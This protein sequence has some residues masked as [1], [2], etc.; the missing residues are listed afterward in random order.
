MLL[1]PVLRNHKLGD[2]ETPKCRGREDQRRKRTIYMTVKE[3]AIVQT[4]EMNEDHN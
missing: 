4:K 3:E 1:T 2:S